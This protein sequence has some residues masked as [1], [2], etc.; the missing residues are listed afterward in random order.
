M[1]A[2]E[3]SKLHSL[4]AR[5][6]AVLF[7]DVLLDVCTV[8][9]RRVKS[10]CFQVRFS[11]ACLDVCT[12]DMLCGCQRVYKFNQKIF[13]ANSRCLHYRVSLSYKR[14]WFNLIF[15]GMGLNVCI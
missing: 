12:V 10:P 2:R 15:F 7:S 11:G 3:I 9:I 6:I 4:S 1:Y 8:V 14:D 5:S 13:R